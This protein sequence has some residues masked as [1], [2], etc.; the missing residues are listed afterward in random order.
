MGKRSLGHSW[1]T[2]IGKGYQLPFLFYDKV[3]LGE[4]LADMRKRD[5]LAKVYRRMYSEQEGT[6]ASLL[7]QEEIPPLFE[8]KHLKDV[9]ELYFT[10]VAATVNLSFSPPEKKEYAYLSVFNNKGWIPI[11]WGRIKNGKVEF[12]KVARVMLTWPLITIGAR[13]TRHRIPLLWRRT[14]IQG[15]WPLM[16]TP[17]LLFF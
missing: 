2:L 3:P 5:G 6:L 11:D 16:S 9:S 15:Y 4:H 7:P 1:C 17:L 12:K 8:D 10:P 14:V 13:R